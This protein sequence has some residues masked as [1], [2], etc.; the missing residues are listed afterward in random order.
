MAMRVRTSLGVCAAL[1]AAFALSPTLAAQEGATLSGRL[2]NSLSGDPIP[3]ATVQI[4]ELQ[5]QVMS[6]QDGAFRF[7]NVPP[8]TYHLSVRSS[9]YSARRTETVVQSVP[10]AMDITVDP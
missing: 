1:V 4:D 8:G 7:E 9:G 2:L 6:G 3:G 5:R 10:V